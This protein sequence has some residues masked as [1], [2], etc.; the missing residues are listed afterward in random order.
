MDI[1]DRLAIHD[2]EVACLALPAG[3]GADEEEFVPLEHLVRLNLPLDLSS[4]IQARA[5]IPQIHGS[6][7]VRCGLTRDGHY[8]II[9]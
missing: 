2:V 5:E 1:T 9:P 7:P 6:P 4:K 8:R 3:K